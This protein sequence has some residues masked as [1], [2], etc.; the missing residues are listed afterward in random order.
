MDSHSSGAARAVNRI[1]CTFAGIAIAV[2]L[3]GAA[4][5]QS[6]SPAAASAN[7]KQTTAVYRTFHLTKIADP[8]DL[9]R[10]SDDL[11]K[12]IPGATIVEMPMQQAITVRGTSEEVE[13]AQKIIEDLDQPSEQARQT[14]FLANITGQDELNDVQTDLRNLFP[15]LKIYGIV[16]ERA[17]SVEGASEDVEAAHNMIAE[18]DRP[19]KTYRITYTLT[20]VDNGNRGAEQRY[21]LIAAAGQ[22]TTFTEGTKVPIM[23]AVPDK[24]DA[25]PQFQYVDVGLKIQALPES[26]ANGLRLKT[27]VEQSSVA[28]EKMFAGAQEPTL[29]QTVLDGVADLTEG[30]PQV[31]GSLDIPGTTRRLEIVVVAET[32]K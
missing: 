11:Q 17:I 15:E 20:E 18:L 14:F 22:R 26:S 24:P 3:A 32:V 2:T 1:V 7:E 10:L 13:T 30:K 29:N 16:S 9:I 31:L 25:P 4:H 28:S 5:A 8:H 19:G 27:K 21:V 23:T 6:Q 12:M